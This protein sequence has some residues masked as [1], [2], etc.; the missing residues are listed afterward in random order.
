MSQ[1][2]I[3]VGAPRRRRQHVSRVE[4]PATR[5]RVPRMRASPS[6]PS[7]R[8]LTTLAGS[9]RRLRHRYRANVAAIF[10]FT[11]AAQNLVRPRT[12][13]GS[14]LWRRSRGPKPGHAPRSGGLLTFS[15]CPFLAPT[16]LLSSSFSQGR[17]LPQAAR[18]KECVAGHWLVTASTPRFQ[19]SWIRYAANS[20]KGVLV[21]QIAWGAA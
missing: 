19:P 20:A 1:P 17:V 11:C 14:R 7:A 5:A 3:T 13:P 4:L 16:A 6:T 2:G 18:G 15:I 21:L 8:P 10:T 9:D 12:L